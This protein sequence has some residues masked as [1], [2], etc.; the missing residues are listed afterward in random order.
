[1][2]GFIRVKG[3]NISSFQVEDF[4]NTHPK[5]QMSAA[6]SIPA[7][8]GLEDDIVVYVVPAA[9]DELD[10]EEIRAWTRREM[11]KYMWP[12]HIRVVDG[13]PQTPTHKVEKY[14]LRE[15]I[16]EEISKG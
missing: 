13:L 14:K 7:A 12:R 8:E 11:P 6:F 2:G 5:I 16:L 3:E 10:E 15:K 1:M 9:G 4:V